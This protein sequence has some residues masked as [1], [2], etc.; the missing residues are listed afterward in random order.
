M[1]SLE[2]GF[3][4]HMFATH[5]VSHVVVGY[6]FPSCTIL[7]CVGKPPHSPPLY[8]KWTCGCHLVWGYFEEGC[9]EH[10][11]SYLFLGSRVHTEHDQERACW[12]RGVF[13]FGKCSHTAFPS[14]DLSDTRTSGLGEFLPST[15]APGIFHLV[16]FSPAGGRCKP[17]FL[18]LALALFL[19]CV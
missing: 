18:W 2:S 19:E 14:G 11:P 3:F 10:P 12:T 17:C 13:N 7:H 5:P 4:V 9:F 15:P 16:R 6:T 8:A 1:P